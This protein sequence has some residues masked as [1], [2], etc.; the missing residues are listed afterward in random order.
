GRT[1]SQHPDQEIL[2]T[3]EHG[4]CESM[5]V[6]ISEVEDNKDHLLPYTPMDWRSVADHYLSRGNKEQH[7]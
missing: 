4:V 6:P 5:G 3:P 7:I 2:D 1:T